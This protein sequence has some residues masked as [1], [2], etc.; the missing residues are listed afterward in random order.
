MMKIFRI[1]DILEWCHMGPLQTQILWF[2]VC[3]GSLSWWRGLHRQSAHGKEDCVN[4]STET[5]LAEGL[6]GTTPRG[7]VSAHT[8]KLW[9][10]SSQS[11]FFFFK[12]SNIT[13]PFG[14]LAVKISTLDR[15]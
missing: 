2:S 10:M 9:R 4:F 7:L 11:T 12:R 5:G 15:C 8:A 14:F 1:Q 3:I 13:V 6:D